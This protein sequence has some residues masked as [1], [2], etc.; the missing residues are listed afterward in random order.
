MVVVV[1]VLL[2]RWGWCCSFELLYSWALSVNIVG[3]RMRVGGLA[4]LG[5]DRYGV[6][7]FMWAGVFWCKHSVTKW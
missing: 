2:W 5:H 6:V 3:V 4:L 7:P 1:V